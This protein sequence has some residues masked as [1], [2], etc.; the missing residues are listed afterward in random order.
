MNAPRS[1]VAIALLGHATLA[2][3]FVLAGVRG[4][5]RLDHVLFYGPLHLTSV[6]G[7]LALS[8]FVVGAALLTY[9]AFRKVV[10][11]P[12]TDVERNS[13]TAVFLRQFSQNRTGMIGLFGVLVLVAMTLLTPMITPYDPDQVDFAE[14][15]L[16]P[17][18]HATSADPTALLMP[19]GTDEF[20]RD[21]FS[22]VLFGGRISLVIGLVAVAI[23]ATIG[24]FVGATAG[25][26]AGFAD[27]ALMWFVDLLLSLPSLV[28]LLAIVGL[29]RP[30]G[31][32]SIFLIVTILGLTSWMSV[33]RIVRSQV[34]SLKEQEFVQAARALGLSPARIV[35]RHLIPNALAPVIVYCSLAVGAV[36]LS[37]ASLS[38]LGLGVAPP[39]STWGTL[40]GEGK[41]HLMRAPWIV[42]FPGLAILTAV[43]SFNLLG[44]GLRDALD[45]KLRGR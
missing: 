16:A 30:K 19:M 38:F 41:D 37:E 32:D 4:L 27:R 11:A 2:A 28:L 20:G 17:G 23:A 13:N 6:H 3:V 18:W 31:V 33:S 42:T 43:M 29:F 21:L 8:S 12:Q 39:T 26:A 9:S 36:I 15:L 7:A 25:Y 40:V 24:V 34:L 22:R 1:S 14:K 44:D 45:P 10:P 5:P 35:A